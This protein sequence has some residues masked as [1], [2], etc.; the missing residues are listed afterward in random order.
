MAELAAEIASEGGREKI[1][2]QRAI[3]RS[4][5]DA[6]IQGNVRVLSLL[7]PVLARLPEAGDGAASPEAA[8]NEILDEYIDREI[9]RRGGTTEKAG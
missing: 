3:V 8:D 5:V 7:L 9:K 6:A 4:L 2:R 1:T